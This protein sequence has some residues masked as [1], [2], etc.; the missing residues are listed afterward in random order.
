MCHQQPVSVRPP[1]TG[2]GAVPGNL[3]LLDQ[4]EALRWVQQNIRAFGGDPGLVTIFGESAGGISVS[5][6]VRAPPST[7]THQLTPW[8]E[9]DVNRVRSGGSC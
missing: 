5:L 8:F 2:D 7:Y 6:L 3:G 1:S 4:V 9:D